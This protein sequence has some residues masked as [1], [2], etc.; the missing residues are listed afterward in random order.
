MQFW[1]FYLDKKSYNS[2]S[3]RRS[4]CNILRTTSIIKP[5]TTDSGG[6]LVGELVEVDG[7]A[8]QPVATPV[9]TRTASTSDRLQAQVGYSAFG[10]FLLWF[11]LKSVVYVC[12]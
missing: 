10:G 9:A 7:D 4:C 1:C 5:P 2:P 8:F 3:E 11:P 12:L 6:T